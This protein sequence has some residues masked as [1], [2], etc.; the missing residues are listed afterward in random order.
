MG[1]T[2]QVDDLLYV[3]VD[4][5]GADSWKLERVVNLLKE[6]AVGVIPTDTVYAALVLFSTLVHFSLSCSTDACNIFTLRT[7]QNKF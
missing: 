6:G 7:Y 5:S 4:P 1:I 3:E 2:D